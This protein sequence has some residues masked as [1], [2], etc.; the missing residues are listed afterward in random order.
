E[1]RF[2]EELALEHRARYYDHAGALV[3]M[4]QSH[5][6]QVLA[7]VA[8]EP[9]SS[10]GATDLREA[11]AAALRATRIWQDDPVAASARGRYTAG[12]IGAEQV[13]SY[14]DEPGVD[15]DRE[16]ETYAE[17]VCEVQTERWAGVPFVLR[18]GKA[19]EK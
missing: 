14:V 4:I 3:D 2:D 17:I 11:K 8:L 7:L 16:I 10:L 5:L 6:L 15:P 12:A 13:V 1:L 9:P 18:S 19:L